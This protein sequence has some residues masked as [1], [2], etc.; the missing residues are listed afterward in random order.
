MSKHRHTYLSVINTIP[1]AE[2]YPST[3]KSFIT[4]QQYIVIH[5]STTLY[6]NLKLINNTQTIE[7]QQQFNITKIENIISK[8]LKLHNIRPNL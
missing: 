7:I 3:T 6:R 5:N 1:R 8:N 4:Q 2:T